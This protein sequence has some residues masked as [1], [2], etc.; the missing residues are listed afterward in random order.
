MRQT[1]KEPSFLG[2]TTM[3]EENKT[4]LNRRYAI[5]NAVQE[6]KSTARLVDDTS[7]DEGEFLLCVLGE[8]G[9]VVVAV[10]LCPGG[11]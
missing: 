4:V 7:L 10:F 1:L 11:G 8:V 9:V 2:R 6:Q 3:V 5:S